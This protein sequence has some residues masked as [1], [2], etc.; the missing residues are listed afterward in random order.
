MKVKALKPDVSILGVGIVAEGAEFDVNEDYAKQLEKKGLVELVGAE[1]G[2]D[3]TK[4]DGPKKR[5]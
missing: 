1:A 5:K 3:K 4:P 2:P